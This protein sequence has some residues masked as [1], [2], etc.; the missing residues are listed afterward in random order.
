MSWPPLHVQ[1]RCCALTLYPA[2]SHARA[3]RFVYIC[4]GTRPPECGA[5]GSPG[6]R[7]LVCLQYHKSAATFDKSNFTFAA[8]IT[9]TPATAAA[10]AAASKRARVSHGCCRTPGPIR[11]KH[12]LLVYS[13]PPIEQQVQHTRFPCFCSEK[14]RDRRT[15]HTR[16]RETNAGDIMIGRDEDIGAGACSGR[17]LRRP[18]VTSRPNSPVCATALSNTH[19]HVDHIKL[20]DLKVARRQLNSK[21]GHTRARTTQAALESGPCCELATRAPKCDH[22]SAAVARVAFAN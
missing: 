16:G 20:D 10:T 21:L 15:L 12:C 13:R 14:L 1:C 18:P 3:L 9:T 2:R 19:P 11:A 6:S 4:N 5:S 8:L 17:V 7:P 22:P